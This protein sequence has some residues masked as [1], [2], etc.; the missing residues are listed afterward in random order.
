MEIATT[1]T[2]DPKSVLRS[3]R[4]CHPAGVAVRSVLAVALVL[5]GIFEQ[6]IFQVVFGVFVFA[7]GEISV[8][9]QLKPYLQAPRTVTVTMTEDEYKTQGPDRAT[10]RTWTTFQSVRR[11]GE[12]WVLR[13]SNAAAMALPTAALDAE[14]TGAFEALMRRKGLLK[15]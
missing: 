13:I 5:L 11:R 4:A 10:S 8:R 2:T 6:S 12:F 1:F 7:F 3:Y 14:Q 15:D 9:R